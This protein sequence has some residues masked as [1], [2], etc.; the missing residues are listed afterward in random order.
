MSLLSEIAKAIK[1][2]LGGTSIN[3]TIP[4]Y[5]GTACK[6]KKSD[7]T[8]SDTN[9]V[10]AGGGFVG[11]LTGTASNATLAASATKLTTARTINGVAFDGTANITVVDSTK[12]PLTGEGASGTWAI[13]I[14]GNAATSTNATTASNATKLNS[15]VEDVNA[16]ANTIV[17]RDGN[18]YIKGVYFHT[19][20]GDT[21]TVASHYYVETGSDGYV[22]PKPLASVKSEIAG[23]RAPLA[24]PALTGTPTAPTAAVGTNTT[25]L[26]T[27]AFVNA[28]IANAAP[29][30]TGS[31]ASGTW[32]INIT[33]NAATATTAT[34][35]SG[36]RAAVYGTG[37]DYSSGGV[38]VNG[39][40]PAN[41]VFPT[42][43][44]HQPQLYASSLQ[45]R[46]GGDFRF[47]Q[48]GGGSY[49]NVTANTFIGNLSGNA[50]TATRLST[51]RANYKTST[52]SVVVGELMWKNYGN[53]HTIFDASHSTTPI[54]AATNNT[55]PDIA[56]NDGYPTL[57]GFNG[58]NTYGVRVDSSRYAD[59]ATKLATARTIT[60]GNTAKSFDGSANIAFSLAEIGAGIIAGNLAQNGYV[61]FN[62]GLIIQWGLLS[63]ASFGPVTLTFPIAFP[64]VCLWGTVSAKFG[65]NDT[66]GSFSVHV[67]DLA[68]TYMTS[69]STKHSGQAPAGRFWMAIGY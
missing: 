43:G 23:D 17:K 41:T 66:G 19:T 67:S 31:G 61:K 64:T 30:K 48:Q 53:G 28:N 11:N 58:T 59:S 5:D 56:W 55:N 35:V 37:N 60:V 46:G 16:T 65:G 52:D 33:G 8:I 57:M 1:T 34:N 10:T 42:I 13:N 4:R 22:R 2:K 51:T 15:V 27:T 14:T 7:V 50:A 12:A 25:Q 68:T 36:G 54:G 24:S 18:G 38:E 45:L 49:A 40:G 69:T 20:A 3:N 39:N 32:G 63:S 47:Y 9:V 29:T 44:F 62:N 21:T 6:L 26:A